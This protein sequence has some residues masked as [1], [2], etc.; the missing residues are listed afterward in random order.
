MAQLFRL[1]LVDIPGGK[2]PFSPGFT[3]GS[4]GHGCLRQRWV[5]GGIDLFRT[6]CYTTTHEMEITYIQLKALASVS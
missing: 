6:V 2:R 5:G 1:F 3:R 4:H